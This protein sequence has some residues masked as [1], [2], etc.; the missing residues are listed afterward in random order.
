MKFNLSFI[1]NKDKTNTTYSSF[2]NIFSYYLPGGLIVILMLCMCTEIVLRWIFHNSIQGIGEIV[3]TSM[4]VI[5]FASL[6]GIQ[7][8]KGH[9]RMTLLVEKLSKRKI[10]TVLE[11]LNLIFIFVIC[12]VLLYPLIIYVIHLNQFNETTEFLYIPLWLVA[13]FMPLGFFFLCIRLVTQFLAEGKKI[14]EKT[15]NQAKNI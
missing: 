10:G 9:V 15:S 1:R 7:K 2:E 5:T 6:A 8:D 4:V 11:T 14:F 3:E 13:I 12:A